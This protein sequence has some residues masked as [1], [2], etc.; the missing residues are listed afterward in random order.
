[1]KYA[2]SVVMFGVA[3]LLVLHRFTIAAPGQESA[4]HQIYFMLVW[5]AAIV[6][7]GFGFVLFPREQ[8]SD[9]PRDDPE[10]GPPGRC[11]SLESLEHPG[12]GQAPNSADCMV[13]RFEG[14]ALGG[15]KE[16]PARIDS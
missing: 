11:E 2:G 14:Y 6:A 15:K 12:A 4:F 9:E 3:V 10:G 5:I 16:R 13:L 7:A 8:P 1:M